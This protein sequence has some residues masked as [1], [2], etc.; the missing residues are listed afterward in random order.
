M[1]LFL[2]TIFFCSITFL[3]YSQ[4]GIGTTNPH[5][6]AALH[7]DSDDSGLLIPRMTQTDRDNISTPATGLLIYQTTNTVGFYYYNS[8]AWVRLSN[9]WRK[10]GNSLDVAVANDDITFTSDETSITFAT[11][12]GTSAPMINMFQGGGNTGNRM[13]IAHS[14]NNPTWGIEYDD[15]ADAFNFMGS[16]IDRVT[17]DLNTNPSLVVHNGSTFNNGVVINEV[18]GN[19]DTR[20]ESDNNPN[21]FGID[22]GENVMFAGTNTLSLLNNGATVN[23]GVTV[24]YVASFYTRD[25]TN[26]TAVQLGSTEYLMDIGNLLLATYG[27]WLP[28]TDNTFD[29]GNSSF[30]WDD[31]YA[32][33]GT[34]NTS[35][36]RLKKN[37]K[38]ITYGLNEVLQLNPISFQWKSNVDTNQTKLGFSAQELLKVL[39]EVV[40]THDYIYA[41]DEKTLLKKENE[42]LGVYYSDIIPVLTKAIQEQ[43]EIIKKLQKRV[44]T[45]EKNK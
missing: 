16:G 32:T 10:T 28:Y 21:A 34:I 24:D 22:A 12:S 4:V 43:Q 23:G 13:V 15:T 17:I 30:R 45:L 42:N 38:K 9:H 35:D 7:I 5:A 37:I 6:S 11:V 14:Q 2:I 1:K 40:K 3:T 31:V 18:G 25:T 29:I 19:Y 26:G 41:D 39:P 20:I 44:E 27:S 36:E 8:T 33:N